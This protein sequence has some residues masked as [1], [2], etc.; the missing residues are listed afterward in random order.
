MDSQPPPLIGGPYKPP[1]DAAI[2]AVLRCEVLG[3][4][5]VSGF[6]DAPIPWPV[7]RAAGGRGRSSLVVRDDLARAVETESVA[8]VCHHFGATPSVVRRWRRALGV[9]QITLGTA[10]LRAKH[11]PPPPTSDQARERGRKGAR[12]RW[13]VIDDGT[14]RLIQPKRNTMHMKCDRCDAELGQFP[15]KIRTDFPSH[16]Q[17]RDN[18][19]GLDYA[20]IGLCR[21][22]SAAFLAWVTELRDDSGEIKAAPRDSGGGDP[23]DPGRAGQ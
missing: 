8:A 11:A 21:D 14:M 3:D 15:N 18:R 4:L 9:D 2:G 20:L 23:S 5:T 12:Q 19:E 6:T 7:G 16:R 1:A 10:A 17:M 13:G 22:C